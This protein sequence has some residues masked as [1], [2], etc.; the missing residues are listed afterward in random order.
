MKHCDL[1][2]TSTYESEM[3]MIM[4]WICGQVGHTW[5]A[6][7]ILMCHPLVRKYG[8]SQGNRL[9]R[10]EIDLTQDYPKVDSET[11]KDSPPPLVNVVSF[12]V[13][14]PKIKNKNNS[15]Q[16]FYIVQ[17]TQHVYGIELYITLYNEII[18]TYEQRKVVNLNVHCD[19]ISNTLLKQICTILFLGQVV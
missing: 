1:G 3:Y 19:K 7:I 9:S 2:M 6:Y 14:Q 16:T 11:G 18:F 12:T 8:G 15:L 17:Q 10:L 13:M 4:G 5:N